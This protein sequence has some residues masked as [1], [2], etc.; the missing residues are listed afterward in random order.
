MKIV[1]LSARAAVVHAPPA[2][3]RVHLICQFFLASGAARREEIC[4][5]L[6]RNAANS[7]ITEVHLLNERLY[8]AAEMG[9]AANDVPAKVRQSPVAGRMTFRDAARYARERGL[10]GYIVIANADIFFDASLDNLRRCDI[11]LRRAAFA[12]LRFEGSDAAGGGGRLF[13]PR[14]DSQDVWIF[15]SAQFFAEAQERAL[16]VV[17]G[18]P[19]CDNKMA[20]LL[21]LMGFEVINDPAFVRTHHLHAETGRDYAIKEPISPPWAFVAPAGADPA[22]FKPDS[23]LGVNMSRAIASTRGMTQ[24][25]FSDNARIREHVAAKLA[26]GRNF[27]IPRISGIENNVACF[28]RASAERGGAP[29]GINEY[30]QAVVPA[31]KRDAGVQLSSRG[32]MLRYAELYL[33]A[34]EQCELFCAWESW[35]GRMQ[36]I[37]DSHRFVVERYGA[38]RRAVWA[39]ALDAFNYIHAEPWTLALRGKRVLVVSAF[40]ESIREKIPIREKI[41][42]VD[43]FPECE[44]S[45]LLPPQ[46]QGDNPSREFDEELREFL[47]RLD[48]VAHTYDVALLSCGGYSNPVCA[49]LFAQ[50]KSAIYVGGALQMMFGVLGA[51]WLKET[52]DVVRLYLNEHWSRPKASE[53]PRG[54]ERI[55]GGCYF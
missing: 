10:R 20:Y 40:A 49:H 47:A 51:R 36:H 53:R 34:F 17:L 18:Q 15:H 25:Q 35:G 30:L 9:F 2:E 44:I 38:E 46:T 24:I 5:C 42:G 19:G 7:R 31:M 22:S 4:E 28:A 8:S 23:S 32:A 14:A 16:D 6:R 21:M 45:V 41:Y 29:P 55:E 50:G 13:G 3:D 33:R 48:A 27:V 1:T 43:L 54:F 12:Q 39:R 26:A 52:P 37:V 11:H